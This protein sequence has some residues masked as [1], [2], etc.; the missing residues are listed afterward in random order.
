MPRAGE[1]TSV[2]LHYV[3]YTC[4]I[5]YL[6]PRA[7][8]STSESAAIAKLRQLAEM[9]ASEVETLMNRTCLVRKLARQ[10]WKRPGSV[11]STGTFVCLAG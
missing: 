10:I 8:E 2:T 5:R 3:R 4:Y 11:W 9:R 7:G 1:S 6:L